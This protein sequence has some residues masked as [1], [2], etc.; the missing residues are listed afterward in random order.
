MRAYI[1]VWLAVPLFA[2]DPCPGEPWQKTFTVALEPGRY[3][4]L[5]P[6][7]E[8]PEGKRLVLEQASFL[9]RGNASNRLLAILRSGDDKE[10]ATLRYPLQWQGNT[11]IESLALASPRLRLYVSAGQKLSLG[12]FR[13]DPFGAAGLDATLIGCLR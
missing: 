3:D 5:R 9:A 2:Q 10:S 1:L 12:L 4:T 13:F 7:F 8:V 11:F 6:V